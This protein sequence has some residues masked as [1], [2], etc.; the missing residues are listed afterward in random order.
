M[1]A[2]PAGRMII[3]AL[4]FLLLLPP[5]CT[6]VS[7]AA[8]AIGGV[9]KVEPYRF[10]DVFADFLSGF[11][12]NFPQKP[13]SSP[14]KDEFETTPEFEARRRSWE[15][16]QER[17]VAEYREKF[18][19]T[20]PLYELYDLEF[21]F[22]RYNAD[23]GCFS[24]ITSSRFNV[25]DVT[26]A[27]EGYHLDASCRF[28]PMDRY[29]EIVINNV[30]LEREKAKALKAITPQLRMRVGFQPVPPFPSTP[31]GKLQLYFHHVSIYDTT[32]GKTLLRLSDP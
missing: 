4:L 1:K 18:S 23:E 17:A 3:K 14:E 30:C 22:G 9:V 10:N 21:S 16:A 13:A 27:C 15:K 29:A 2:R 7:S 26:P 5:L 28:G 11:Q 12:A 8:E 25:V 31:Q 24:R 6:G 20:V 32:S 19:K